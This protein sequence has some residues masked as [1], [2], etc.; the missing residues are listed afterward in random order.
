RRE[1]TQY[2]GV[3]I[4]FRTLETRCGI[5]KF[6]PRPGEPVLLPERPIS[7]I[8]PA[9]L[10][11]AQRLTTLLFAVR[12]FSVLASPGKDA[13]L[14]KRSG[15]KLAAPSPIVH[16]RDEDDRG[17]RALRKSPHASPT[18]K[19]RWLVSLASLALRVGVAALVLLPAT[20]FGQIRMPDSNNID[21]IVISAQA[22]NR[23]Q[24]GEYE[25]WL[26]RGECRLKQGDDWA[27]C[28]EAVFWIDHAAPASHHR[29]TVIAYLEG[30]VTVHQTLDREPLDI[31]DQR[32]FGRFF[33]IR[34]VQVA[35]GVVAGK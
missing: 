12:C 30:N 24:E 9:V 6:P 32:W 21:K 23:W 13:S 14:L 27:V 7:I 15:D 29:S 11:F 16:L 28:Q 31:Q 18:R 35:A 5:G 17:T 25:V 4:G 8:S 26:L 22:A 34:D 20:L 2:G 19:R 3:I 33:T 10:G 1:S